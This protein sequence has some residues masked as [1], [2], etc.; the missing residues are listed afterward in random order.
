MSTLILPE[1]WF[2][3]SSTCK[4]NL[5][6]DES[7]SAGDRSIRKNITNDRTSWIIL[8][9]I[10]QDCNIKYDRCMKAL[11]SCLR[12]RKMH[13]K[14]MAK[15]L[16]R[17]HFRQLKFRL[18]SSANKIQSGDTNQGNCFMSISLNTS[19]SEDILK[20]GEKMMQSVL[21]WI[22][23]IYFQIRKKMFNVL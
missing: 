18:F 14:N 13:I 16:I 21:E 9:E 19:L 4:W 7:C 15:Y 20:K 22:A 23:C 6:I 10:L 17:D 8:R 11:M 2:T 5:T 1:N 3:S 12:W